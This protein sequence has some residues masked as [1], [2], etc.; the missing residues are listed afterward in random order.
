MAAQ[1]PHEFDDPLDY[2]E[3]I[4][5]LDAVEGEAVFVTTGWGTARDRSTYT[6]GFVGTL[7]RMSRDDGARR[8]LG[9]EEHF[10][11]GSGES[12]PCGASLVLARS[13]FEGAHLRTI[14]GNRFFKFS[15][16][17]DAGL[18]IISDEASGP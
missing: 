14:D 8:T 7:R 17:T 9:D 4:A 18:V 13:R 2:D 5:L 11:V 6:V 3:L 16:D 15:I 10:T 12:L 1:L